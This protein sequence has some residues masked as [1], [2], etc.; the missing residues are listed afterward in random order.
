MP[1]SLLAI[2]LLPLASFV[3]TLLLGKRWGT[4]AHWLPIITVLLS[5]GCALATL[6]RVQSGTIINQDLYT[7]DRVGHPAGLGRLPG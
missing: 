5:F 6:F 7:W 2:P 1:A 4:R 3:L